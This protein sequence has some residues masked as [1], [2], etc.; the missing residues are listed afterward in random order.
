MTTDKAR[1]YFSA[2]F[3]GSLDEGLRESFEQ[4]LEIDQELKEEYVLFSTTIEDLN[5]LSEEQIVIP[6]DLHDRIA[7]RMQDVYRSNPVQ[8]APTLTLWT[9]R[10]ALTIAAVAATLIIGGVLSINNRSEQ[11]TA[12]V[13]PSGLPTPV[14]VEPP[15][16]TLEGDQS[17]AT[18]KVV[19][20]KQGTIVLRQEGENGLI[21][22]SMSPDQTFQHTFTVGSDNPT[23]VQVEIDGAVY[24]TVILPGAV[25]LQVLEGEGNVNTFARSLAGF[26]R[27]PVLLEGKANSEQFKWSFD[28]VTAKQAA[29]LALGTS[30]TIKQDVEG[31]ITITSN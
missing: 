21:T 25:A 27:V 22:E 4:A 31:P 26:Y 30:M 20:H 29:A 6:A 10:K 16:V 23:T 5:S 9:N 19:L 28:N 7:S 3:E 24:A 18:V 17:Q 11:G 8:K 1:G 14:A 13:T 15:S 2:Y 12:S